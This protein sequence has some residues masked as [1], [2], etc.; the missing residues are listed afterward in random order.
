M[1]ETSTVPISRPFNFR[2]AAGIPIG[3]MVLLLIFDPTAVDYFL[4]NLFY[5]P[6]QGFIGAHSY[7]LETVLHDR[8][9]QVVIILAVLFAVGFAA[10]WVVASLRPW[11]RTLGYI[12]LAMGLSTGIITPLKNL[13]QVQCPWSLSDFGGVET[14]TPLLSHRAPSL[15]PG[16]CW[17]GGHAATGFSLLALFF[18]LR[19]R[20]P[21]A[22]RV[23][24]AVAL[25]LGVLFSLG[26]MMQG[27][28]FLSHN[29]W[30]LLIDWLICL[31]CY[32]WLL[33]RP[34]PAAVPAGA[35]V[36]T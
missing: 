4:A 11:R 22:A 27:A 10:S 15:K 29:V 2:L 6:G 18:A 13:T 3:I 24:L 21:R 7:W 5:V 25:G 30:T 33:Y 32:R 26:R 8:A 14:H 35:A 34:Q 16:L 1:A 28:H 17:P 9:K 20:K 19:D 12:V 36:N 31:A 23:A